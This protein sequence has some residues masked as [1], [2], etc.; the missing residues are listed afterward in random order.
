MENQEEPKRNYTK[1][2]MVGGMM[3]VLGVTGIIK[4]PEYVKIFQPEYRTEEIRYQREIHDAAIENIQNILDK[5]CE[6]TKYKFYE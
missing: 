6:L 5:R 4:A 3:T 2:F 1:A